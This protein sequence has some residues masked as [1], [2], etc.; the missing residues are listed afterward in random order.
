M[1]T[2]T[3]ELTLIFIFINFALSIVRIEYCNQLIVPNWL[4]NLFSVDI[5]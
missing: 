4:N 1:F 2:V 3:L 5:I